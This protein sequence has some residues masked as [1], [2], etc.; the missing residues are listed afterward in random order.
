MT[1][2]TFCGR[3]EYA[4]KGVHLL[5][6]SGTV[7]FF[8]SSKCRKNALKLERDKRKLKWTEAFHIMRGKVREKEKV[9]QSAEKKIDE[10]ETKQKAAPKKSAK[11]NPSK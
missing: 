4:F 9:K 1:K 8:C 6:N 2:C 11:K 7:N 3:E 10:A 5:R